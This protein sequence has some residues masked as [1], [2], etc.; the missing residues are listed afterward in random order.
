MELPRQIRIG[1]K[2]RSSNA[3]HTT[4]TASYVADLS[5]ELAKMAERANLTLAAALLNLA[6]MEAQRMSQTSGE[7]VSRPLDDPRDHAV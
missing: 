7:R 6:G 5:R 4:E 3:R 2:V 1:T